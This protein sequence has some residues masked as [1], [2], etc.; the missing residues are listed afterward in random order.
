[1]RKTCLEPHVRWTPRMQNTEIRSTSLTCN[2]AAT[3]PDITQLTPVA[4]AA[5]TFARPCFVQIA[6]VNVWAATLSDAVKVHL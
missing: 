5:V 3:D 2:R 6:A 1:M 4:V